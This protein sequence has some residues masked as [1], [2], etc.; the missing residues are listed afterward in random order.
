MESL[1]RTANR[2]CI[3]T[4]YEISNSLLLDN[5]DSSMEFNHH[6]MSTGGDDQWS[7]QSNAG[8]NS[9]KATISLWIKRA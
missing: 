3:S 1:Q 4:G 8:T 5:S 2:G 9:K 6:Q 7:A